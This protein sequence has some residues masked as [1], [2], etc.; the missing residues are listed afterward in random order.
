MADRRAGR[1]PHFGNK[2]AANSRETEIRMGLG[3]RSALTPGSRG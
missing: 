1:I 2:V 3:G